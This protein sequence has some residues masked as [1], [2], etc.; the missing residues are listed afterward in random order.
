MTAG[1]GKN[2]HPWFRYCAVRDQLMRMSD[3]D[4]IDIGIKRGDIHAI[5]RHS[6]GLAKTAAGSTR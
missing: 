3:R 6:A 1:T 4:L 2:G 5:A